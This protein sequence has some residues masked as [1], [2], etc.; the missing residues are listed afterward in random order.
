MDKKHLHEKFAILNYQLQNTSY[1]W[2]TSNPVQFSKMKKQ[3]LK[4]HKQLNNDTV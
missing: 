2:I 3:L 1:S 4:L